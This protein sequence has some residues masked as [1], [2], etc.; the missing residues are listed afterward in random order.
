MSS[1]E[2]LKE[3]IHLND[4]FKALK[5]EKIYGNFIFNDNLTAHKLAENPILHSR[6]KYIDH[7]IS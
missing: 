1:A 6:A 4:T 7:I 3:L 2:T 5:F